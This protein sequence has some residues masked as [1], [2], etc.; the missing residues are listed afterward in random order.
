MITAIADKYTKASTA[1]YW[2]FSLGVTYDV[3]QRRFRNGEGH[4][5][6]TVDGK[7][8]EVPDIFFT[9]SDD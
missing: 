3:L 8:T 1:E 7:R 5:H 2:G 6:I 4:L 9:C